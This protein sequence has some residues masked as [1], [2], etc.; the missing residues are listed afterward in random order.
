[1][2]FSMAN[3]QFTRGSYEF[4]RF[5]FTWPRMAAKLTTMNKAGKSCEG[6]VN[7]WKMYPP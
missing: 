4:R 2:G 3:C 7:D 6:L 1:M 5:F